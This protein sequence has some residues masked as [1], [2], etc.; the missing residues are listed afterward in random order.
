MSDERDLIRSRI[1]IVDLVQERT[2][3]KRKGKAWWG[4]CPFH[5]D[6]SPSFQVSDLTGQYRCWSCGAKG[7][8]FT[9]VMEVEKVDFRDAL[10]QLAEKAGV[11]LKKGA[12]NEGSKRKSYQAANEFTLQFYSAQLKSS[13]Q[14]LDYCDRRGLSETVR[15]EWQLGYAP[16]EHGLTNHLKKQGISLADAKEIFLVDGDQGGGYY[17]K[18]RDRLMFPIHDERGHLVAWGGRILGQGNPKYI[19]SGDTPLYSKRKVL[20]GMNRAKEHIA[21]ADR[22][23]LVEGYMDVIA[24]HRAGVRNTVASLGTAMSE[25]QAKLLHRWCQ[26]VTVLYDSD[27]AGQKAAARAAEVL[28]AEGLQVKVALLPVGQDPDSLLKEVGPEAVVRVTEGGLSPVEYA[29]SQLEMKYDLTAQEFWDQAIDSLKLARDSLEVSKQLEALALRYP[30]INNPQEAL[31][32]LKQLARA[33]LGPTKSAAAPKRSSGIEKVVRDV[34]GPEKLILSALFF[35]ELRP[36]AWEAIGEPELFPSWIAKQV[37]LAL[38]TAFGDDSPQ[39][40]TRNWL[41]EIPEDEAKSY[42][43]ELA[44]HLETKKDQ[45]H[46]PDEASLRHAIERLGLKRERAGLIRKR[47]GGEF[48]GDNAM[49]FTKRWTQSIASEIDQ[50]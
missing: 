17:D 47:L 1:N 9:W 4:L 30:F 15:E 3:L 13:K 43:S 23:I 48:A 12:P 7:D 41:A 38:Y 32:A 8:I 16:G 37:Q 2:N 29:I 24:C 40:E 46:I 6:K 31:R 20:Y 45:L 5:D 49:Q 14:T 19:N 36:I 50:N 42:L 34:T 18:F 39:G 10:E 11:E 25:E 22:A 21:A 35:E 33:R 44:M 26:K 28:S 27:A